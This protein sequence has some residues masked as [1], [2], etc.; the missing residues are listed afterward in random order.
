MLARQLAG[1]APR[2]M[3]YVIDTI[4]RLGILFVLSIFSAIGANFL[5]G[6]S[7]GFLLFAMFLL[8]WGYFVFCEGFFN[9]RTVGKRALGLRVIQ[10]QGYPITMWSAVLR[11]LLRAGDYMLC[12]MPT[13]VCMLLTK[14]F[15]RLGDLFASTV[16][17]SERVARLPSEPVIVERIA[18]L[19]RDQIGSYVP[20]RDTLALIDE[21]LGR[22]APS[23]IPPERGHEIV[24][25]LAKALA[26]KLQYQGDRKR[27]ENYPMAF[28]AEVYVTFARKEDEGDDAFLPA[29]EVVDVS[30]DEIDFAPAPA[31]SPRRRPG[32]GA[33][34]S[35]L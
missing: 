9:G 28:L 22:R 23:R 18:S 29:A 32:A 6:M 35:P 8:E 34:R 25:K 16:V 12:F 11:N 15:Q 27:L 26:A 3:A 10:K 21:F 30:P 14:D 2:A 24:A 19:K 33:R 31:Q 4:V 5:P 17:V 7:I 13:V 1:P 20:G